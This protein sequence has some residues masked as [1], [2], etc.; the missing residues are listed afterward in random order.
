[1]KIIVPES[2]L[3]MKTL[4]ALSVTTFLAVTLPAAGSYAQA[5][6]HPASAAGTGSSETE[7]LVPNAFSPNGDGLNDKLVPV[8]SGRKQYTLS[9]FKVFNRSGQEVFSAG[10]GTEGWDGTFKGQ[11]AESATYS[12]HL[13]VSDTDGNEKTV[14]GYVA[15]IR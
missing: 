8:L 5:V 13:Q 3:L 6:I 1:M 7:L 15:L 11:P 9:S 10:K 12:Y 4:L 14:T 2:I